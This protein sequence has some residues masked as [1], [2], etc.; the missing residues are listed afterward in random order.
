MENNFKS[1]P[2]SFSVFF[3]Q[4]KSIELNEDSSNSVSCE[5]GLLYFCAKP[6][7]KTLQIFKQNVF[8]WP[9]SCRCEECMQKNLFCL[10]GQ[11]KKY[12]FRLVPS[13]PPDLM[14]SLDELSDGE[15]VKVKVGRR[16]RRRRNLRAKL[17]DGGKNNIFWRIDYLHLEER[18]Y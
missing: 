5:L 12:F 7:N 9:F 14:I 1:L 11:M 3:A 16:R 13:R 15:K 17:D 6:K 4:W 10:S 18:S 2:V 8:R